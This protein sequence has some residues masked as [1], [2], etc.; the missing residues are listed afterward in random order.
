[1]FVQ[2]FLIASLLIGYISLC[3][4]I[5][6]IHF[7]YISFTLLFDLILYSSKYYP[8]QI[9]L[10]ILGVFVLGEFFLFPF[11]NRNNIKR[12]SF[13]F[14]IFVTTFFVLEIGIVYVICIGFLLYMSNRVFNDII[15]RI[16]NGVLINPFSISMIIYQLKNIF[17]ITLIYK[18]SVSMSHLYCFFFI[19]SA[20]IYLLRIKYRSNI[21]VSDSNKSYF[22]ILQIINDKSEPVNG[23]VTGSN[24]LNSLSVL[25]KT[26]IVVL[27][28]L[29][30]GYKSTEIAE[31][32][33]VTNGTIYF[34]CKNLREKLN[35]KNTNHLAKYAF[36]NQNI[37]DKQLHGYQIKQ[38]ITNFSNPDHYL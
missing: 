19:S 36:D 14:I 9:E 27:S 4:F 34:H 20:T 32:L 6:N 33:F 5:D 12:Y 26:E 31:K 23:N 28:M 21:N 22:N 37:L 38:N 18:F 13:F 25:T 11:H 10:P 1:M 29:G 16:R 35:I 30:K 8:P 17:V 24:G 15:V 7:Y 2:L 3:F